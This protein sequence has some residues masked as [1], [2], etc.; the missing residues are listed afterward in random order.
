MEI[1]KEIP[2]KHKNEQLKSS[3]VCAGRNQHSTQVAVHPCLLYIVHSSQARDSAYVSTKGIKEWLE[4]MWYTLHNEELDV[5]KSGLYHFQGSGWNWRSVVLREI[6]QTQKDTLLHVWCPDFKEDV[7]VEKMLRMRK[8]TQGRGI[9]GCL[10][11]MWSSVLCT[12][13]EMSQQNSIFCII[14]TQ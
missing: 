8:Q 5:E 2:H 7:T 9:G 10:M 11:W 12:C 13:M 6:S 4:K 3:W 1:S 14:N